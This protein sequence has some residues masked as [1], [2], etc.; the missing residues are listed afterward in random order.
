M[1]YTTSTTNSKL[2]YFYKYYLLL[3]NLKAIIDKR[4]KK[5]KISQAKKHQHDN[6]YFINTYF[7]GRSLGIMRFNLN[8]LP[9]HSY[10]VDIALCVFCSVQKWVSSKNFKNL[11]NKMHSIKFCFEQNPR[12]FRKMDY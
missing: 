2:I 1:N 10:H 7:Y 6:A 5:R 3:D 4:K 8:V 9:H 11:E 12:Y